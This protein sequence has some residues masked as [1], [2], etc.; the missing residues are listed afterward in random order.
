MATFD[1][2]RVEF[3]NRDKVMYPATGTTKGDVIEYFLGVAPA[4]LPHLRC[5]PV[6]RKRWPNGVDHDAFFEKNLPDSAPHWLPARRIEH[7]ARTVRYPLIESVAGLAWLGQQAA[8]EAHVPQ[9]RFTGI[10]AVGP[11]SAI[12]PATRLVF[13][14]DPGEGVT[15]TQCAEVA[16]A[17]RDRLDEIGLPA[18][19]V[20]SGGKGIHL[21]V[22]LAD[23]PIRSASAS[24]LAHRV[25][26]ILE[27][28]WPDRVTARMSR[29]RRAGKVFIDWS[30]NH[31]NKTTICPYSL[32]G[33]AEPTVAA[34]RTWAELEDP[35]L[36][37]LR[38]DEVIERLR[39]D[40]DLL[41]GLD[42]DTGTGQDAAD[43]LADY[44]SKRDPRRTPEPIPH[45]NA[46]PAPGPGATFVVQEHHATR[47]HWDFRL[48]RD[49]VLVS[50]A[51]PKNLPDDPGENR[52]AIQTEDHPLE[53][54]GFAGDIPK[55]EYGGGHVEIYDRGTYDTEKWRDDE[56]IVDL[57]GDRLS[58]RY[59]L[60][61]TGGTQ[62]LVHRMKPGPAQ[63]D[64]ASSDLSSG[65]LPSGLRPMLATAGTVSGLD[66]D[67]WAFEGK[68][69]GYR[70]LVEVD[71]G[72]LRL[73][74]RSGRDLTADYPALAG[75]GEDLRN[76]RAVLD[77]ELVVT[78][79]SGAPS[80]ALLQDVRRRAEVVLYLF[81]VLHL[82]GVSLLHKRYDDRRRVLESLARML[83]RA[84]VPDRIG[85]T[86]A[87]ALAESGRRGLE[88][89][90]A[91]RRDSTYL[92]G[93]R[94][95]AWIKE[96][97]WNAAEVVIGGF[98]RGEGSRAATFGSLLLGLPGEGGLRYL[99]R[100]G[101]GF[102]EAQLSSLAERLGE[103]G[104][105]DSPFVEELP[106]ADRKDA[107]WVRP[108]LVG[109]VRYAEQ[110]ASGHLRHP[111]WR[112]LR[113]DKSPGE[114]GG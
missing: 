85:G 47:L 61:R 97:H 94:G 110:T 28:Q 50:W 43:R 15:L 39:R 23:R 2:R 109:E 106:A 30:Q 99:G 76:H 78:D 95:S 41:A 63:G 114:L 73:V 18:F 33:R 53:Y 77:G 92:P 10:G 21:Y 88:G 96:K 79:P 52:L 71:G 3:T 90:V 24:T 20:T 57:H 104:C 38:Y 100:V 102:T 34:P 17:I 67:E 111:S 80:F 45:A 84:E 46:A 68:Y 54:G 4:M 69:D 6:T 48:E 59:A 9:W 14:L 19:P 66:P 25:A 42:P 8:L 32:R 49:G 86:G 74:S 22:P 75:L 81:D 64:Q 83:T 29:T 35:Q 56:V 16:Q 26:T 44:R 27:Q 55:G 105:A 36:R 103:L 91:K 107:C 101:T 12:G 82:D 11:D 113:P 13:D 72:R 108:E 37:Q 98:R 1:G 93:R 89:V 7:R 112:G 51:V 87:Q 5:R 62:W 31:A 65:G 58:G 70:V 40:G 60:I